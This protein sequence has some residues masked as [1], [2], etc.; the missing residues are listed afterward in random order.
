MKDA[1]SE[2]DLP[3]VVDVLDTADTSETFRRIIEPQLLAVQEASPAMM[4]L[5]A[6]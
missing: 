3:F 4:P 5:P 6:E 2:S 1:F